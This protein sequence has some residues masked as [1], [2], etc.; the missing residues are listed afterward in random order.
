MNAAIAMLATVD[1]LSE[2]A[3]HLDRGTLALFI[4][5]NRTFH[6]VGITHLWGHLHSLAP[7]LNLLMPSKVRVYN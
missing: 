7:L 5:V 6:Q 3:S 4:Q 2:I 1:I